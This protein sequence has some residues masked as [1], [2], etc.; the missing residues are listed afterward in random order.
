MG[1]GTNGAC[2]SWHRM[3]AAAA[4][5]KSAGVVPSTGMVRT[6]KFGTTCA[7]GAPGP[8][9][10][11]P[12]SLTDPCVGARRPGCFREERGCAVASRRKPR[13]FAHWSPGLSSTS[14]EHPDP[15]FAGRRVVPGWYRAVR[16]SSS[17][18]TLAPP[19]PRHELRPAGQRLQWHAAECERRSRRRHRAA[20]SPEL[21]SRSTLRHPAAGRPLKRRH[22]APEGLPGGWGRGVYLEVGQVAPA[23]VVHQP[24]PRLL[25]AQE[26]LCSPRRSAAS[27]ARAHQRSLQGLHKHDDICFGL[28]RV[29]LT[30]S[31]SGRRGRGWGV[32]GELHHLAA[33]D[34]GGG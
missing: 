24:A 18:S 33:C 23:A 32:G 21:S 19:G 10:F 7:A 13:T 12:P 16:Q 14:A 11:A 34:P 31:V 6:R 4:W 20:E 27:W 26:H 9:D 5:P 1:S 29:V 8:H 17:L 28:L 2:A 30:S 22:G 3:W 15:R 25:C